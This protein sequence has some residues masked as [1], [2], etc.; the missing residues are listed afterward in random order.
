MAA[1]D[2]NATAMWRGAPFLFLRHER[3][4]DNTPR[5]AAM[6]E[7]NKSQVSGIERFSI[8]VAFSALAELFEVQNTWAKALLS[9]RVITSRETFFSDA[10]AVEPF[11]FVALDTPVESLDGGIVRFH[12]APLVMPG[13][14]VSFESHFSDMEITA[15][16]P[17]LWEGQ[18]FD[19]RLGYFEAQWS[20][21][22]EWDKSWRTVEDD[23]Q[24]L[25][26][27]KLSTQ[28]AMLELETPDRSAPGFGGDL[29]V[30]YGFRN[31]ISDV[32]GVR[33]GEALL[34][35]SVYADLWYH[36]KRGD[37]DGK[38]W[39]VTLGAIYDRR[40]WASRI[41]PI[42]KAEWP[43][44]FYGGWVESDLMFKFYARVWL[45]V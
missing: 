44:F 45:G 24:V 34:H 42:V 3:P 5:Q 10:A 39:A 32:V 29:R 43:I 40:L 27:S 21:L 19:I 22:S 37:G 17:P 18:W 14:M 15:A 12:G 38:G 7:V 9:A 11:L 20:K 26:E 16:L 25:F 4:F 1:W 35:G 2:F 33:P 8:G 13:E 30:R 31:Q 41:E 28:G 36:W 23:Y 6:L